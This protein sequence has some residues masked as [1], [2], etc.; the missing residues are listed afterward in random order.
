M[1]IFKEK[2]GII[3]PNSCWVCIHDGY[4]YIG[5]TLIELIAVLNT[6]WEDD[7]YLVG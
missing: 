2:A 3:S 5:N 1:H 7:Q 6:K 4:M